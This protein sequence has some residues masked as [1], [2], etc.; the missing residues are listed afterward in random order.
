MLSLFTVAGKV[1]LIKGDKKVSFN[2]FQH[3]FEIH[4][5]CQKP[6]MANYMQFWPDFYV[7]AFA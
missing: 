6:L 3:V 1:F 4:V 2:A 5:A 7:M